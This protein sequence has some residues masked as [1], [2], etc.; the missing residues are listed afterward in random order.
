[1]R[2]D[3]EPIRQKKTRPWAAA[4][5]VV[6]A[7]LL[8][9]ENAIGQ[10][11]RISIYSDVASTSCNLTDT[12][13]RA[14]QVYVVHQYG[15]GVTASK[16]RIE[17]SPG[18][19][20][21]LLAV[22]NAFPSTTGNI[23]TGVSIPYGACNTSGRILLLTID[24]YCYGTSEECAWVVPCPVGA[25]CGTEVVDCTNQALCGDYQGL[26][27]N[28]NLCGLRCDH[29]DAWGHAC[30]L[31]VPLENDTWGRIKAIYEHH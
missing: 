18:F 13:E 10:A 7:L 3:L 28:N 8:T 25:A 14:R 20:C 19:T 16:F 27:V 2:I 5:L 23:Y 24:L 22:H 9:P 12:A 30:K 15:A 26:W 21:A 6:F 29:E 17:I 4:I 1:M 31:P 11:G